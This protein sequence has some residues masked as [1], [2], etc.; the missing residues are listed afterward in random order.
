MSLAIWQ[1]CLAQLKD[2]LS[3]GDFSTWL[4]PLQAEY[5][6]NVLSLYSPNK[7]TS[8]WVREKYM[9]IIETKLQTLSHAVDSNLTIQIRLLVGTANANKPSAEKAAPAVNTQSTMGR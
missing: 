6:N 8:E 3:A 7:Y 4:R 2:E 1:E 9:D 5:N